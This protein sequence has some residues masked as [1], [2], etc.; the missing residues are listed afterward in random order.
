MKWK[1]ETEKMSHFTISFLNHR[2]ALLGILSHNDLHLSLYFSLTILSFY[3]FFLFYLTSYS[4]RSLE[5]SSASFL[6]CLLLFFIPILYFLGFLRGLGG[7][8]PLEDFS[9]LSFYKYIFY[10]ISVCFLFIYLLLKWKGYFSGKNNHLGDSFQPKREFSLFFLSFQW[11]L[12]P[13]CAEI[14]RLLY[15][16]GKI[17][18]LIYSLL[19]IFFLRLLPLTQSIFLLLG[20]FY[21]KDLQISLLFIPFSF[22]SWVYGLVHYSLVD[23]VDQ[24]LWGIQ[25][26][27]KVS[28]TKEDEGKEWMGGPR[29]MLFELTEMAKEEGYGPRNLP[30]FGDLFYSLCHLRNI[31]RF[32]KGD[33]FYYLG[34][35]PL[36]L[37]IISW[38]GLS[39]YLYPQDLFFEESY[40]IFPILLL[41]RNKISSLVLKT[42]EIPLKRDLISKKIYPQGVLEKNNLTL[43]CPRDLKINA[44]DL[45]ENSFLP[46]EESLEGNSSL[47]KRNMLKERFTLL[48]FAQKNESIFTFYTDFLYGIF[49]SPKKEFL[50]GLSFYFFT[51]GIPLLQSTLLFLGI[52]LWKDISLFLLLLPLSLLSFIY[53]FLHYSLD[54]YARENLQGTL[55]LV[56]V[57]PP[58]VKNRESEDEWLSS[59]DGFIFRLKPLALAEG[60]LSNNLDSLGK[61]FYVLN[62]WHYLQRSRKKLPGYILW[63]ILWSLRFLCLLFLSFSFLWEGKASFLLGGGEGIFSQALVR[64]Q[65]PGRGRDMINHRVSKGKEKESEIERVRIN[66]AKI[67]KEL[68]NSSLQSD[69]YHDYVAEIPPDSSPSDSKQVK[70]DSLWAKILGTATHGEGPSKNKAVGVSEKGDMDGENRPQKL[71]APKRETF[72]HKD[73]VTKTKEI[74]P[75]FTTE[76]LDKVMEVNKDRAKGSPIYIDKVIKGNSPREVIKK[77]EELSSEPPM[78]KRE[79]QRASSQHKAREKF[80][81][82][83]G[84]KNKFAE[85]D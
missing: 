20:V 9:L 84:D 78:D 43:P 26:L 3:I 19:F 18:P 28:P 74:H 44:K 34:Y 56:E 61:N 50:Y 49:E 11:P 82:P 24:N 79:K 31:E 15:L 37:R 27:V 65:A 41:L 16:P 83:R 59:R 75:S 55:E 81:H 33:I 69:K 80:P 7:P 22:L 48:L 73:H 36:T 52:F 68:G 35:L 62:H 2:D 42:K 17:Y 53:G 25:E 77:K 1:I 12:R 76:Y 32:L 40:S 72:V 70:E 47:W 30:L 63:S 85:E 21:W 60:Y 46:S 13:F 14:I 57:L 29:G 38:M 45:R 39:Y 71:V 67:S 6:S 58:P 5:I 54:A 66:D 23:Y 10:L 51:Q 64:G 4:W 8:L